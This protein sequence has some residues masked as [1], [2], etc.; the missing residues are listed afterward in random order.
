[1]SDCRNWERLEW[2]VAWEEHPCTAQS[3]MKIDDVMVPDSCTE[4]SCLEIYADKWGFKL[5]EWLECARR[6][7][8]VS[9][10]S[11]PRR[12]FDDDLSLHIG[13][14]GE[15]RYLHDGGSSWNTEMAYEI[16]SAFPIGKPPHHSRTPPLYHIACHW[17]Y[18]VVP[19]EI[20]AFSVIMLNRP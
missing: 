13:S 15:A 9:F 4:L 17:R 8:L 10:G 16:P 3:T 20:G 2:E 18:D 1:M 11:G 12:R 7:E 6:V 5:A 19:V 14:Q